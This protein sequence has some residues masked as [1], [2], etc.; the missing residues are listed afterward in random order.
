M[1]P[2]SHN[3][4]IH[5]YIQVERFMVLASRIP[6]YDSRLRC[7]HIMQSFQGNVDFTSARLQVVDDA[8]NEVSAQWRMANRDVIRL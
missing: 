7:A 6:N 2:F 4:Y 1:L 5:T 8:V 3:T